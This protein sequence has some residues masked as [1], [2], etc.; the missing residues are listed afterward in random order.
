MGKELKSGWVS[1]TGRAP[2]D[3]HPI[4]KIVKP[5][6]PNLF[7]VESKPLT[8][9][10]PKGCG[11]AI[12]VRRDG[13]T[14]RSGVNVDVSE[15]VMKLKY[16]QSVFFDKFVRVM[17]SDSRTLPVIRMHVYI[18]NGSGM[19]SADGWVSL[20]GR[21]R[22][23]KEPIFKITR[24]C[25]IGRP[26]KKRLNPFSWVFRNRAAEEKAGITS[27]D[28]NSE[29]LVSQKQQEEHQDPVDSP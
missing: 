29:K 15:V 14:M 23:D 9:E 1:L 16:R 8:Q 28:G 3:T 22:I 26:E 7:A 5:C 21:T 12:V 13:A 19:V 24:E 17:P 6:D 4:F 10:V 2:G 11:S 25:T 27:T 18:A 20:T